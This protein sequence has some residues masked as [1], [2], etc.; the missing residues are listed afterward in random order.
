MTML[1]AQLDDLSDLSV[2]LTT[3]GG[4][5]LTAQASATSTTTNVVSEVRSS[6]QSALAAIRSHLDALLTSVQTSGARAEATAWTGANRDRFTAA[7]GDFQQAMQAAR[8]STEAVFAEFQA[9]VDTMTASLED[10]D[11][12]FSS[13]MGQ[14]EGSVRSMSA[15]VD[16]QRTNLDSVMNTG[17]AF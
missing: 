14:A 3:T 7:Y 5:V 13:A 8:Q 15:A 1:G 12:Q 6:A 11:R 16:A 4:D 17:M 10:Y 9:A 2:T